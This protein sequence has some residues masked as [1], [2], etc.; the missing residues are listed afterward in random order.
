MSQYS[1]KYLE[2]EKIRLK[3]VQEIVNENIKFIKKFECF[4]SEIKPIVAQ[5]KDLS[6]DLEDLNFLGE[7]CKAR[8]EDQRS[9]TWIFSEL[10]R[11]RE[12]K[13]KKEVSK[14]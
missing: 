8:M 11:E 14:L 1:I 10:K 6:I 13:Q 5:Q 12:K 4:L 9:I 7:L 3:E 2:L